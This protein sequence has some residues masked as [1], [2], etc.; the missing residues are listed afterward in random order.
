MAHLKNLFAYLKTIILNLP[1]QLNI[2]FLEAFFGEYLQFN[3]L[4]TQSYQ[5]LSSNYF[6]SHLY[7]A[8]ARG[9]LEL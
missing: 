2:C 7:R 5:L 1:G 4:G 6:S 8:D 9:Q 3:L